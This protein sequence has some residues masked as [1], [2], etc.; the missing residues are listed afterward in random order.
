M[1]SAFLSPD[2]NLK[3]IFQ[4]DAAVKFHSYLPSQNLPIN[5]NLQLLPNILS[6]TF[7]NHEESHFSS[8]GFLI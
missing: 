2:Y 8:S 1:P 4:K 3:T 5:Q 7:G 6:V